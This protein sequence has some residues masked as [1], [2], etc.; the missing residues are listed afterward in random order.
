MISRISNSDAKTLQKWSGKKGIVMILKV[1]KLRKRNKKRNYEGNMG[2]D[3]QKASVRPAHQFRYSEKAF[4]YNNAFQTAKSPFFRDVADVW[5]DNIRLRI[6]K[7]SFSTYYTIVT[8][9]LKP[10]FGDRYIED[11]T[12]E[13]ISSFLTFATGKG[14]AHST[15]RGIASVLR[16]ILVFAE[17]EGYR[18][19]STGCI[20]RR[21]NLQ[22]E[23]R[24]LNENEWRQLEGFLKNN[25]DP[26]KL[27][28]LI[29]MYTGIRLGE[30]CALKWE[31]ISLETGIL[32]IR[33]TV[34]RIRTDKKEGNRKTSIV[35]DAPKSKS[36]NRSIPL[37]TF[38]VSILEN[39][40]SSKNCFVLTGEPD[41]FIEPRTFQN[42][43]KSILRS[44]AI[45]DINFHALRHTF[46][47]KCVN[48]GFDIKTLSEILGH[49]DVSVTLNTYV[50]PSLSNMK[51]YMER[52]KSS[53]CL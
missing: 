25:I 16:N 11:I 53:T 26:L 20:V 13:S 21:K 41:V 38:L 31:D 49:S 45:D 34:Q 46:A 44:A 17:N 36:S 51:S 1:V 8:T 35:F 12:T 27:G 52:L 39:S 40:K 22:R 3:L 6:K 24:I 5:L 47:T 33:R 19:S 15:I 23:I 14:L 28:T 10:C 9:H 48:L 29:C 30:M 4:F 2:D 37:P 43:F 7:S 50:H 32:T 18:V 42:R